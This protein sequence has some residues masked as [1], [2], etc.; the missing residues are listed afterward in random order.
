MVLAMVSRKDWPFIQ[1]KI[2]T[3]DDRN[4]KIYPR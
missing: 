2:F 3:L 4:N 1:F